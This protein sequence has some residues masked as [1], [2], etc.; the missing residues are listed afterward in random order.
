MPL[1]EEMWCYEI[2]VCMFLRRKEM[3][4]I[5]LPWVDRWAEI[6]FICS[7][8]VAVLLVCG[9]EGCLLWD[10]VLCLGVSVECHIV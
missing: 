2:I 1:K 3:I 10:M 7:L 6:L 8:Q 5:I 9:G 4:G